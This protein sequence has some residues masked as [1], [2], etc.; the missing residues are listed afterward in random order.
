MGRILVGISSWHDQALIASG[1]FYPPEAKTTEARL[2]FYARRFLVAEVDSSYHRMPGRADVALWVEATPPGF[3]FD[4]KAYSLLTGHPTPFG[5]LPRVI[6]AEFGEAIPKEGNLYINKLP[7][8]AADALW[9]MFARSLEPLAEAGKLGVVLFQY[10][11]WFHVRK[12]NFDYMAHCRER[13]A[14]YRLAVEFRTGGWL[15][16]ENA[17]RTLEFLRQHEL[18]LVCV[19]EPQGLKSSVPPLAEVTAATGF[20]RFHGRNSENWETREASDTKF[21]Y[22]YSDEELKEWAPKIRRMA[23]RAEEVHVIFKNKFEDYPVRNA[24]QMIELLG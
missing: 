21:K 16:D 9:A 15:N 22:L 7:P 1:R 12:E 14:Q 8:E 6:R 10:P 20:V 19:D 18:A 17:A 13:L 11:P 24:L 4:V 3:V 23:E 5:A 2:E